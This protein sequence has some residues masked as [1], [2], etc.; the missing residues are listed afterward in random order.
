VRFVSLGCIFAFTV[1]AWLF[2]WF[3]LL[4]PPTGIMVDLYGPVLRDGGPDVVLD[5]LPKG[6]I[7]LL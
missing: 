6:H 3:L 4:R 1:C 2:M 7:E 5:A